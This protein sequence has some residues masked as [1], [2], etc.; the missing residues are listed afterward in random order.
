MDA[1]NERFFAGR[2]SRLGGRSAGRV[3]TATR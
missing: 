2:A 3:M 1:L